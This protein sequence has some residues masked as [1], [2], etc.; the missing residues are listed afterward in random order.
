MSGLVNKS[1]A[2]ER[3]ID[4]VHLLVMVLLTGLVFLGL[5]AVLGFFVLRIV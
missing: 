2:W 4:L 5:L 1:M 3:W